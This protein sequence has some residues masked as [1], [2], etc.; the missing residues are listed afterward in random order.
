[1][2]KIKTQVPDDTGKNQLFDYFSV[3]ALIYSVAHITLY[4]SYLEIP[5]IVIFAGI[6]SYIYVSMMNSRANCHNFNNL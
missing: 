2:A 5:K 1:M 3:H 4:E 6:M